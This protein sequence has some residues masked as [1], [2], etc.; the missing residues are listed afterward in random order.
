MMA[1][2]YGNYEATQI[3]LDAGADLDMKSGAGK[4]AVEMAYR[5]YHTDC[6]DLVK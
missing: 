3:L 1:A 2:S 6:V 5:N 4:T